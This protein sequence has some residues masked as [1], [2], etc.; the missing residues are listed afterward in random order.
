VSEGRNLSLSGNV[1]KFNEF[2][3]TKSDNSMRRK[4]PEVWCNSDAVVVMNRRLFPNSGAKFA[5]FVALD[6]QRMQVTLTRPT[7]LRN[8]RDSLHMRVVT[9]FWKVTKKTNIRVTTT[10]VRNVGGVGS[11]DDSASRQQTR[12]TSIVNKII[13]IGEKVIDTIDGKRGK[14]GEDRLWCIW[15]S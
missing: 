6:R 12:Q 10:N 4:S 7:N 2:C 3:S 9:V 1:D 11:R 14:F 15:I 5:S 8:T 13:S